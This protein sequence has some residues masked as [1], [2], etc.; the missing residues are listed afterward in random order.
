MAGMTTV[1]QSVQHVVIHG[2]FWF[3]IGSL[4]EVPIAYELPN[5]IVGQAAESR[6]AAARDIQAAVDDCSEP[7]EAW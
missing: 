1:A 3:R 5:S 4:G 2:V 7:L 6:D